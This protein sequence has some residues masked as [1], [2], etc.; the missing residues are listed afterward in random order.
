VSF[1]GH[2]IVWRGDQFRLENGKLIRM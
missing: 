1:A 2:K